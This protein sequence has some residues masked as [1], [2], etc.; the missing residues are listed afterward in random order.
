MSTAVAQNVINFS[1]LIHLH[2]RDG[3]ITDSPSPIH[4]T[5]HPTTQAFGGPTDAGNSEAGE[6]WGEGLS[7]VDG[8]LLHYGKKGKVLLASVMP[9]TAYNQLCSLYCAIGTSKSSRAGHSND[10]RLLLGPL[11]ST[12]LLCPGL[13]QGHTTSKCRNQDSTQVFSCQSQGHIHGPAVPC[14]LNSSR[15]KGTVNDVKLRKREHS[16]LPTFF[17]SA[18]HLYILL[19]HLLEL[20]LGN[21]QLIP[22]A[23]CPEP[24]SPL[25]AARGRSMVGGTPWTD[26]Q[27]PK[28]GSLARRL[29]R[30][31]TKWCSRKLQLRVEICRSNFFFAWVRAK[32]RRMN[33]LFSSLDWEA[34]D[35][36]REGFLYRWYS[37]S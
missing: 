1:C 16:G 28:L 34:Y 12:S 24:A 20:R 9:V 10:P 4:P 33:S 2:G 14:L 7:R 30:P 18:W 21:R 37:C 31:Q 32:G 13:G 6:L 25:W 27:I 8:G 5:E 23:D 22:L 29:R 35:I 3:G 17:F 19:Q 36:E 26:S 11:G 15:G